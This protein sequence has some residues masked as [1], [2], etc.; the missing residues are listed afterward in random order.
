MRKDSLKFAWVSDKL[1][2]G[3]EHGIIIGFSLWKLKTSK[4]YVTTLDSP[5][6]RDFTKNRITGPSPAD[7]AVLI[8][9]AGV[10][11]FEEGISR[12]RQIHEH[13]H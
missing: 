9:A 6:H 5:G 11:E 1:K 3:C 2:A 13:A 12:N 10:G 8:V 4:D 7:C